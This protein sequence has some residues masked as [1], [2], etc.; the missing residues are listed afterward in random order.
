[1]R[2]LVPQRHGEVRWEWGG[3]GMLALARAGARALASGPWAELRQR[4]R[5]E[6]GFPPGRPVIASG[7]QPLLVHPGIIL[8]QFF[9]HVLPPE[10]YGVWV[11]VDT[12]APQ[13]VGFPLPL[14]RRAYTHHFLVLISNPERRIL[15][16]I[17]A[18]TPELLDQ[19]RRRIAERLATLHNRAILTRAETAW[20]RLPPPEG[21]WPHWLET[22]KARLCGLQGLRWLSAKALA[23]TRAFREFA[24][25]LLG[26][27]DLFLEAYE[28]AAK[29]AGIAPLKPG[30]LPF[31]TI[32]G[33]RRQPARPGDGPLFPRALTLTLFLRAVVCDF[34]LHGAGGATYEPGVDHLFRAAL[35]IEPPSWGW[36]TGTFLLPEPS[37]EQRLP[38]REF[39]FFLHD[40][41]EVK[42]ALA[43]PLS[44][45]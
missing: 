16:A 41:A 23:E 14:R 8:R 38:G 2:D 44:A 17:P 42:T 6:L 37:A 21:T 11:S 31:W 39:P 13:D 12:D 28:A 35:G 32:R 36:L 1:M 5:E 24:E 19:A 3:R 9:L 43:G 18:P 7:H 27:G 34:F 45:L 40:L 26:K 25:L 4:A 15:A 33:G 30:E 22:A 20:K 10:A 29:K